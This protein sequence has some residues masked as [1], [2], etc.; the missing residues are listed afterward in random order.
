VRTY[1]KPVG[2]VRSSKDNIVR[3]ERI[4]KDYVSEALTAS[5]K[6]TV[7]DHQ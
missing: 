4:G 6:R 1:G 5:L 3:P 7:L 2:S